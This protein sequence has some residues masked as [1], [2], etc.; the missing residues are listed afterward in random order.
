MN[1]LGMKVGVCISGGGAKLG[2]AVGVLEIMKEKE[3]KIDVVY[4]T[5]GGSLCVAAL[6]YGKLQEF[7]DILLDINKRSDVIKT[8]WCKVIWTQLTGWGNANG[9]FEMDTMREK[10]SHTPCDKPKL[11][12][13]VGNVM[14]QSGDIKYRDSDSLS[15]DEFLNAVQASCSMPAFMQSK[16]IG[17][18]DCV[19]GGVRDIL[20]LRALINDPVN[21][22]EI[23][24]ISLSP[25][26]PCSTDKTKKILD[27][28]ERG[29]E[30]L[31]NEILNNDY[32]Y[33][34]LVNNLIRHRQSLSSCLQTWLAKE[35]PN[36]RQIRRFRYFPTEDICG[37]TD[38]CK[39]NIL[40]GIHYGGEIASD[41]LKNY[42]DGW[43]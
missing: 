12:G 23:H 40:K 34:E 9:V 11:K 38:F 41:V 43:E 36:Q 31:T 4:G 16:R 27:V 33:V 42:P 25:L 21:V 39:E 29:L 14:L 8:Q 26:Q 17:S 13:V 19:D 20:P 15:K 5:S 28:A 10:L 37:T 24:V 2:F 3:I 18:E 7:K 6:C 32:H 35:R 22:D 1:K 30:L